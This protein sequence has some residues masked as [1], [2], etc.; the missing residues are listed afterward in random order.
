MAGVGGVSEGLLPCGMSKRV[1]E[2]VLVV[3]AR[4]VGRSLI[5]DV[6]VT[7]RPPRFH[8]WQA[9]RRKGGGLSGWERKRRERASESG[10]AAHMR[11]AGPFGWAERM[12]RRE[13]AG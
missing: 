12:R 9:E 3:V 8:G 10:W 11:W 6:V 13:G 1:R 2:V 5:A 7:G 4:L